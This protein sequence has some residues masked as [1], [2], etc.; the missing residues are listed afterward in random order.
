MQSEKG[1]IEKIKLTEAP[2]RIFVLHFAFSI[3]HFSFPLASA[4]TEFVD[5]S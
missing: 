3:Q 4:R 1:L 5:V 2:S